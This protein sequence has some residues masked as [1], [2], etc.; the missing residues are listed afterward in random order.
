MN[1]MIELLKMADMVW[2]DRPSSANFSLSIASEDTMGPM[3]VN[4]KRFW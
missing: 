3:H 4:R 1:V 2:F